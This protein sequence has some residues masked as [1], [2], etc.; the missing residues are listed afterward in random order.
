VL[1]RPSAV[2]KVSG[3]HAWYF[4]ELPPGVDVRGCHADA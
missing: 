2:P 3:I 4:D 1:E